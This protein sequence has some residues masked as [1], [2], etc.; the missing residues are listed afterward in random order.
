MN[1]GVDARPA[2]AV[3]GRIPQGSIEVVDASDPADI[4]LHLVKDCNADF[5][6]YYHFRAS[7][8]RGVDCTFRIMNAGESLAT[9]L[10]GREN[11]EDGWTNTGPTASYD[12]K[13]WFRVPA[14][15]DGKVFSFRH[16]PDYDQCYYA[17]WVPY[18]LDRELDFIAR[19]QLSPRVRLRSAGLSL[20]GAEIPMLVV[21][22]PAPDRL[23]CWL[24]A[25]QHPSEMQSGYFVEAFVDRLV[26]EHDP[27]VRR[28]LERAVFHIV[29]N[30]NPDGARRGHT[31]T[32]AAGANLNREWT[33]PS[34]EKSPEVFHVRALMEAIGVDFSIDCHADKEL[35]CNF[36][37]GPL[38]I[39]SRSAR[40]RR[41]FRAFEH[42][43]A[44]ASPEYEM[45]HP[46]PGGPP[47]TADLTMAWNWIAERFDCLSVLLEQPFKDTSW[48]Q[49]KVQGWSPERAMR[50]GATLPTAIH[51]V[52]DKLR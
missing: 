8:V 17:S 15:F 50:F 10:P 12:R 21:G 5:M 9:R 36:L 25:R 28:L 22:T 2:F 16:T 48:W 26:D 44:A 23:K 45:G 43:W 33:A 38:E 37:G 41:L 20:D 3:S 42:A 31:R 34:L 13:F 52:L 18:P 27:I 24:I 14:R 29:P 39:P 51:G 49:D 19:A 46:Y 4:R 1:V 7:G 40:L 6:G 30:M 35:R 32:N 11:V 47:E